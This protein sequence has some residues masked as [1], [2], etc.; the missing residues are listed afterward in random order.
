MY[1]D[2]SEPGNSRHAFVMELEFVT[3]RL[4]DCTGDDRGFVELPTA[5]D[6]PSKIL[7]VR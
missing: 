5:W 7:A 4:H 3:V 1:R 2:F 6:R